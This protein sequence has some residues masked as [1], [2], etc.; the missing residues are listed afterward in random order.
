M[1]S[2]IYSGAEA[3]DPA[4]HLALAGYWRSSYSASPWT[5]T[6]SAGGTSSAQDLTEATNPPS[7]DT[8]VNGK[9]PANFDGTNDQLTGDDTLE[10][11]I[12]ASAESGWALVYVDAISTNDASWSQNDCIVATDASGRWGVYLKSG[13]G[14][15]VGFAHFD[16]AADDTVETT[17]AT[18]VWQFVQWKYDGTNIKI[19]VNGGAWA[20]AAADAVDDRSYAAKVG[21]SPGGQFFDGKILEIGLTDVTLADATFDQIRAY[22]TRRYGLSV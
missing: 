3:F 4:L 1:S 22:V 15:T 21:V 12:N 16:G 8:A 11:Y 9:V 5:G 19:R 13:A 2:L 20:S 17:I 10:T 18:G 7:T 14:T 6:A